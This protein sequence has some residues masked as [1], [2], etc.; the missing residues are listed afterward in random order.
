MWR[1]LFVNDSCSK[2]KSRSKKERNLKKE[3]VMK[4]NDAD[5]TGTSYRT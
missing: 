4:S 2:S 5:E 1:H 3:V